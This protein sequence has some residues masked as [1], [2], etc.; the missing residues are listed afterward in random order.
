M[1]P[2]PEDP[3]LAATIAAFERQKL[4]EVELEEWETSGVCGSRVVVSCIVR[5]CNGRRCRIDCVW[6]SSCGRKR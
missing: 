4:E 1:A 3:E 2:P 6:R 5:R